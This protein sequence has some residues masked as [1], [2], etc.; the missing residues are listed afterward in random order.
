MNTAV[1][2]GASERRMR[3]SDIVN[4]CETGKSDW[5]DMATCWTGSDKAD[6]ASR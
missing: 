4:V 2:D 6:S 3:G 1:D 5:S